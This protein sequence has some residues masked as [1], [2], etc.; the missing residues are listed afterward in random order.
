M[1]SSIFFELLK[2]G[3]RVR[4]ASDLQRYG[5]DSTFFFENISNSPDFVVPESIACVSVSSYSKLQVIADQKYMKR[6]EEDMDQ[7]MNDHW[8]KYGYRYGKTNKSH[9]FDNWSHFAVVEYEFNES[10]W[11]KPGLFTGS[12][13]NLLL[14]AGY[15]MA[16]VC[17][18]LGHTDGWKF[19]TNG[20]VK[21]T[22]DY[23][24]FTKYSS[25]NI[26]NS[27]PINTGLNLPFSE[28][29]PPPTY[30]Q[31]MFSAFAPSITDNVPGYA[32]SNGA[33]GLIQLCSEDKI[34]LCGFD[35]NILNLVTQC[36]TSA[37]LKIQKI[38]ADDYKHIANGYNI[39]IV[40]HPWWCTG[41]KAV[42]ARYGLMQVFEMLRVNNW[43]ILT[44]IDIS[45]RLNDKSA[46]V[47]VK[48]LMPVSPPAYNPIPV[49]GG[50][51]P[52]EYGGFEFKNYGFTDS[53]F[54]SNIPPAKP[55][56]SMVISMTD[57]DHLR[58]IGNFYEQELNNWMPLLRNF[59]W[60]IK[61]E[62]YVNDIPALRNNYDLCYL[63][64][65]H[66]KPWAFF[67]HFHNNGGW[68]SMSMMMNLFAAVERDGWR[69]I[70]SGDVSAK[71]VRGG[72]NQPD[73][74]IDTHS[75]FLMKIET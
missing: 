11:S 20:A 43:S 40:G 30:D 51:P 58:F 17:A 75:W 8:V 14:M 23:L 35:D 24:W 68:H 12:S 38:D 13:G 41:E 61:S 25:S 64:D 57:T 4:L 5:E 49:A 62:R 29:L 66:S 31:S 39:K 52:P 59:P 6:L 16:H 22:T 34:R 18:S 3:W 45:R 9:D 19:L 48:S 32:S 44:S 69:V 73:Y 33:P 55:I 1:W 46:F 42:R 26:S 21:G 70:C 56:R 71:F 54:K 65:F 37:G 53:L 67:P 7:I 36:L 10:V 2:Q 72:E 28:A 27:V 74:S 50:A 60:S 15:S 63:V 47:F